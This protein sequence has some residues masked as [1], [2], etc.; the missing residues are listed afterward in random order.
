MCKLILWRSGLG[1]LLGTFGEFLTELSS[2]GTIMAGI[3][4]LRFYLIIF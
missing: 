4:V 3:I 1:L 2:H